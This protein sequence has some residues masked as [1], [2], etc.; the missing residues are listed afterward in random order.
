VSHGARRA[1]WWTPAGGDACQL[2][3]AFGARA[4]LEREGIVFFVHDAVAN[5]ARVLGALPA[6]AISTLLSRVVGQRKPR[7]PA[8]HG[9]PLRLSA[10]REESLVQ[11]ALDAS[12]ANAA[13]PVR[14]AALRDLVASNDMDRHA[15]IEEIEIFSRPQHRS[16]GRTVAAVASAAVLA[17]VATIDAADDVDAAHEAS[18]HSTVAA[19]AAPSA[20]SG[21]LADLPRRLSALFPQRA[22]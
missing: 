16:A 2:A 1:F 14:A 12:A 22:V 13:V 5:M 18:P 6:S 20:T 19:L 8:R 15:E 9:A 21:A 17:G 7:E 4:V 10:E 11:L 3:L